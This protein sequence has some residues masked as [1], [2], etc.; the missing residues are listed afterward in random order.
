[1]KMDWTQDNGGSD[2]RRLLFTIQETG[3]MLHVSDSTLM[4]WERDGVIRAVRQGRTV[5][6]AMEEI[7]RFISTRRAA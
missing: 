6:F 3:E 2:T 7:E 4:R 1:M 5:R